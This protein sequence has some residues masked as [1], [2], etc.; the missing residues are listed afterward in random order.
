MTI[1]EKLE[2]LALHHEETAR[3][4]RITLKLLS[5]DSND[6]E[7]V[8]KSIKANTYH[9]KHWTKLPKNKNKVRKAVQAMRKAK[10]AS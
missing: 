7:K 6:L 3:A 5:S 9:G 10:N 4:I 2:Q 1:N 8:K